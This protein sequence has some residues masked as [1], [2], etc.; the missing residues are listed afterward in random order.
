MTEGVE[1]NGRW[2]N[3]DSCVFRDG[4]CHVHVR[5]YELL[6]MRQSVAAFGGRCSLT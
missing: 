4:Q 3:G 1:M 2:F 6:E 5:F